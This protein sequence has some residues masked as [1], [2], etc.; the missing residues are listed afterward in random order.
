V[1]AAKPK[2]KSTE[3]DVKRQAPA[4]PGKPETAPA[5]GGQRQVAISNPNEVASL[6]LVQ[7]DA[8]NAKKDELTIA[9]KGL[10]DLTKQL[11]RAY[12]E[13]SKRIQQLEMKIRELELSQVKAKAS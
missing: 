6:V 3:A 13:H 8:V 10:S 2:E 9:I 12:G 11:V 1:E 5:A 4:A 7:I